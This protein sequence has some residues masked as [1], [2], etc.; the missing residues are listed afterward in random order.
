MEILRGE[1]GYVPG[2]VQEAL[3]QAYGGSAVAQAAALA[4]AAFR[5]GAPPPPRG[6]RGGGRQRAHGREGGRGTE[7]NLFQAPAPAPASSSSA[8]VTAGR[9]RCPFCTS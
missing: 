1:G 2:S 5:S 4:T 8:P 6:A 7:G 3:L 9:L